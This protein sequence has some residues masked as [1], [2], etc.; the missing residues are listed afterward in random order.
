MTRT[1]KDR[2]CLS[3]WL[4]KDP[5]WETELFCSRDCELEF[6]DQLTAPQERTL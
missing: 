5:E 3:C 6:W 2:M 4:P 1:Q